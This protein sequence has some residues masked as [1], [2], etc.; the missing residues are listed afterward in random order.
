MA[1]AAAAAESSVKTTPRRSIQRPLQP[2]RSV[3]TPRP[4]SSSVAKPTTPTS[5]ATRRSISG[6]SPVPSSTVPTAAST[7]ISR[8]VSVSGLDQR[9][10][11]QVRTSSA[12]VDTQGQSSV[13]EATSSK[14]TVDI[15]AGSRASQVL[16]NGDD[17]GYQDALN[18]LKIDA[19]VPLIEDLADWLNN[20]LGK[21]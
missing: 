13:T 17:E 10:A 18:Q 5:A 3:H 8:P 4:T 16:L 20:T 14:P 1:T 7:K 15:A 9:R 6:P 11:S 21:C 12:A 2:T 19:L